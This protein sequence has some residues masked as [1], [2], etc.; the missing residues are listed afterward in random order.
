MSEQLK[1]KIIE[2]L[3]SEE[4]RPQRAR[5]LA[6]DLD[7]HDEENYHE[8]RNALRDL[9]QKGRVVLGAGGNI[10]LPSAQPKR[11]EFVGTYRAKKGGF[12]FVA[13]TDATAHEDLYTP[14]GQ[15]NGAISGDIVKARITNRR[16]G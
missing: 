13:P 14:K 10:L 1:N 2:H 6:R 5:T 11:D 3:K 8:F 16:K 12:G 4:Y 15:S 7:A 9:M